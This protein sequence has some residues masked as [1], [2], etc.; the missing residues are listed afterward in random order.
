MIVP[1]VEPS[2][3]LPFPYRLL[4]APYPQSF[5]EKF[6]PDLSRHL[7]LQRAESRY[8]G[9][10]GLEILRNDFSQLSALHLE[11]ESA[12]AFTTHEQSALPDLERVLANCFI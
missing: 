2:P 12:H 3:P 8:A 9:R 6:G 7:L 10:I 1:P 5:L 11:N 4:L